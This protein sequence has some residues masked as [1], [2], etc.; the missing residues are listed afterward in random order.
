MRF[1]LPIA[2]VLCLATDAAAQESSQRPLA[3]GTVQVVKASALIRPKLR[4]V[5]VVPETSVAQARVLRPQMR[6]PTIVKKAMAR[7]KAERDGNLAGVRGVKGAFVGVVDGKGGCGIPKAYRVTEVSGIRLSTGALMDKNTIKALKTW[8]DK[9][10]K[11]AVGN[12]GGGVVSMRVA[13][14]YACRTRNHK[15]G[16]KLSEHAKGKAIDFSSFTLRDGEVITLIDHWGQGA[17]GRI[18]RRMHKAACGPF[19]TVL[20]PESDRFHRDHFHFDT[21]QHRGGSYCR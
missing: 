19:G 12:R 2:F 16:A 17:R 21:A 3:R 1:L 4:P 8:V 6:P 9:G 7:R 18:L 5:V 13:A 20:G 11:P 10:L 15:A 14:H